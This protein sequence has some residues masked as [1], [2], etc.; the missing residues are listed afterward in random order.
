MATPYKPNDPQWT[1]DLAMASS[2]LGTPAKTRILRYLASTEDGASRGAIAAATE[3]GGS[4]SR[5]LREL[6]DSGAVT[7]DWPKDD[8]WGRSVRYRSDPER[9][10]Y[11]VELWT[12]YALNES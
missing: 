4:L 5:I 10:K 6:E 12:T 11:F 7:G 1:A 3:I 9:V 2:I 8:R